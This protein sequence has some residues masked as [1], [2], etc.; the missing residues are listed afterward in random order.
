MK[1][2]MIKTALREIRE[3]LGRYMAILAIVAL[4][5]GFFV[6]LTVTKPVMVEA[7]EEYLEENKLYDLRLISTIG[8]GEEEVEKVNALDGVEVAEG[9]IYTDFLAMDESGEESVLRA[10]SML[11]KQNQAVVTAG[12]K[13][14][15]ANECMVDSLA[16]GKDAIG[17]TIK[18]SENDDEDTA[19]LLAYTEYTIVGLCNSSYYINYERGTTSLGNGRLKG[20]IYIPEAGFN[21]DYY[22]D[23]YVRL[24]ERYPLYSEEYDAAIDEALNWAEPYCEQLAQERY[25][26]MKED[27]EWQIEDGQRELDEKTADAQQQLEDGRQELLDAEEEIAD[28]EAEIADGWS[29]IADGKAE[30]EENRADLD[31]TLTELEDGMT[32]IE[33]G[34]AEL[35]DRKTEASDLEGDEKEQVEGGLNLAE[36]QVMG[37]KAQAE[38]GLA[39]ANMGEKQLQAAQ[40][41]L[42]RQEENLRKAEEDLVDAKAEVA[43]G[44]EEYEENKRLLEE[45]TADAE[46]ELA[47]ARQELADLEKPDTYVLT[48]DEN[49]G[50]ACYESDSSIIEGIAGVF[51]VFFF[52]VAALVCMTTMARMVEE[53]RTQIGVLKA[54]GYGKGSIV[55]KYLFYSGSAALIGCITGFLVGSYVFPQVIWTAYGIMYRL[56]DIEVMLDWRLALISLV[57]SLLCSMGTTAA[58]CRYEL[59]EMAAQLMR[60]KAP[61]AGKRI[62]LEKI[63]FLW[64]RMSFLVK[65]SMRNIFRY[66]Q[67]FF[68]MVFGIGGCTALLVTGFGV[69]DSISS[70]IDSQYGEI[71]IND[72]NVVFSEP[73]YEMDSSEF[74]AVMETY[75]QEYMIAFEESIDLYYGEETRSVNLVIPEKPE[76]IGAYLNLHTPDG[77]AIAYPGTGEAVLTKKLAEKS[78]VSVGDEVS[79][80]DEDGNSLTVR[81]SGISENFIYNYVYLSPETWTAQIGQ[82]PEYRSAYLNVQEGQDVYEVSAAVMNCKGVSSVTAYEDMR[83]RFGS[84]MESLNYVVLLI[85]ICAGSLAFIVLYNLTN[86]NITERLREIATIKVLGFYRNETA[87]YVFRENLMLTGVGTLVGLVMGKYLHEFVMYKVDIDMIAFDVHIAPLSILYSIL[88]T[89]VFAAVVCWVMNRKLDAINMA[90]SMKSIE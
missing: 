20:F 61:K 38:A 69:K 55:G 90:E 16:Y 34:L 48:R 30:I 56:G 78:G 15:A 27:A 65:V 1:S 59:T 89:F 13:P 84:M 64:N 28:A 9:E 33:D 29:Q 62:V 49:I 3:S 26:T 2:T 5:V 52:L 70:I 71:Q 79:L 35:D 24:D 10:H 45:E 31:S 43:D 87:S 75:A 7:G 4:G 63:P 36:A 17:S 60:P 41:E 54:L 50:Y 25:E 68:M 66:K 80:R 74:E 14:V 67:R 12:R 51:P 73:Y 58:T 11:W 46:A 22:T 82:E 72:L 44:W 39:Q 6:G 23:I 86:I 40:E 53:Q 42:A 47:D 8:F 83:V 81:V 21:A 76:E 85:I 57:V 88:L 37:K 32:Q 77:E 18:V 19:D